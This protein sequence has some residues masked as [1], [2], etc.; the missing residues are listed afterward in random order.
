MY[1]GWC[2]DS[3]FTTYIFMKIC[4]NQSCKERW[5]KPNSCFSP[6]KSNKSG[7]R[8][9]CR[10]CVNEK[11]VQWR[12]NFSDKYH[13]IKI[14]KY[15]PGSTSIEDL[16][17][18][19]SILTSQHGKCAICKKHSSFLSKKLC[20]DH[21]HKTLRVRGLLCDPCNRL[22]GW[23]NDDTSIFESAISYLNR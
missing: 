2:F 4:I 16:E 10:V 18:Y 15:W 23:M 6:M 1:P 5:P 8:N 11:S 9:Q 22:L 3:F 19:K 20:V 13:A 17:K 14:K 7:F 12:K 21:D